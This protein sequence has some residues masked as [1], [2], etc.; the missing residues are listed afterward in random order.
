MKLDS[1]IYVAGHNGMVGGAILQHLKIHNYTNIVT[2][3][4]ADLN[5]I[6]Q[7]DVNI[8]LL[9]VVVPI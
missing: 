9:V 5:L 4:S 7:A 6:N 8:L 1:K 3:S 2:R